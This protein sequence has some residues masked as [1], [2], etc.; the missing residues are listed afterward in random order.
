MQKEEKKNSLNINQVEKYR[1]C[2]FSGLR[3]LKCKRNIFTLT[4]FVKARHAHNSSEEKGEDGDR[5]IKI[6]NNNN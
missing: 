1:Y 6:K 5:A 3:R 2:F 4:K